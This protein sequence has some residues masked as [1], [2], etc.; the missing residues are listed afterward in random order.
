ML[1]L[2]LIAVGGLLPDRTFVLTVDPA[3][4]H[5]RLGD[6]RDRI[7]REDDGFRAAVAAGYEQLAGLFP[8]RVKALDGS[9]PASE[10]ARLVRVELDV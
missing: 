10:L 1:E 3:V 7:E 8:Q 6:E 9:L 5:G 2:N 4:A